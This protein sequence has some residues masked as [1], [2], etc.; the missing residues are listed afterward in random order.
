[1]FGLMYTSMACLVAIT[2]LPAQ[3]P[4]SAPNEPAQPVLTAKSAPAQPTTQISAPGSAQA[5]P[6]APQSFDKPVFSGKPLPGK[7]AGTESWIV[8]FKSRPFTLAAY[9]AE[10]YG[11]RLNQN[12]KP[13]P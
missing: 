5:L 3:A 11:D 10:M 2:A 13:V 7:K 9:R 8:H 12:G 4:G 1:M 6:V